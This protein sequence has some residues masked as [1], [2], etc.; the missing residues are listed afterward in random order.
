MFHQDFRDR[1]VN[2]GYSDKTCS[3]AADAIVRNLSAEDLI[4][5]SIAHRAAKAGDAKSLKRFY[6]EKPEFLGQIAV[7]GYET[8]AVIALRPED[9]EKC[10]EEADTRSRASDTQTE[11]AFINNLDT[12]VSIYWINFAGSREIY[13]RL[14]PNDRVDL[15][16]FLTHP[17]V[18]TD[19]AGSC[20]GLVLP[21]R[22][23]TTVVLGD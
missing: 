19:D 16:T 10:E 5:A 20:I 4:E 2:D 23:P 18:I 1:C 12:G 9:T 11:I 15:V 8:D 14:A 22:D 6:A 7:C 17:W 13:R 21:R 3:C